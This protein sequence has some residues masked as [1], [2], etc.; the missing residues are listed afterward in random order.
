MAS[1]HEKDSQSQEIKSKRSRRLGRS[2]ARSATL[3]V[4]LA[5]LPGCAGSS[6]SSSRP[7]P[8]AAEQSWNRY[9]TESFDVY[10][11]LAQPQAREAMRSF[12]EIASAVDGL[13]AERIG[14]PLRQVPRVR[15]VVLQSRE[16]FDEISPGQASRTFAAYS[17]PR[18][19]LELEDIPT[20]VTF[21]EMSLEVR[22]R[23]V[24]QWVHHRLAHTFVDAPIWLNEGLAAYFERAVDLDGTFSMS[25]LPLT[26]PDSWEAFSRGASTLRD[27]SQLRTSQLLE[28]SRLVQVPAAKFCERGASRVHREDAETECA[29][30]YASAFAFVRLL[31]DGPAPYPNL[32]AT[33]VAKTRQGAS[34]QVAFEETFVSTSQKDVD[35]AFYHSLRASSQRVFM[36]SVPAR[37]GL[38]KAIAMPVARGEVHALMAN[39]EA[40]SSG[41]LNVARRWLA[42]APCAPGQCEAV[43]QAQ[44]VVALNDGAL[45][46]ARAHFDLALKAN[47]QSAHAALGLV[48]VARREA[49]EKG[50]GKQ[51]VEAATADLARLA[52]EPAQLN[53][54]AVV[55]AEA[56][57]LEDAQRF[58]ERAVAAGPQCSFCLDTLA[59]ILEARGDKDR[60]SWLS[61]EAARLRL[62]VLS[63]EDPRLFARSRR[64]A[65]W[66]F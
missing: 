39:I 37:T 62:Q 11:D 44:G 24:H 29:A 26:E 35:A 51:V 60:A 42:G 63:A 36:T 38:A 15:L 22:R 34:A 7:E 2:L 50:A 66:T 4:A 27:L 30:S 9:Q 6:N 41:D 58:A 61:Q 48:L 47:P 28:P 3:L 1:T 32:F 64:A 17:L 45:G 49:A 57:R 10:S 18:L 52:S 25:H 65:P 16:E 12:E 46:L 40:A 56:G 19:P 20:I 59:E 23:F 33:M 8:V 53:A 5:A 31:L 54:V 43:S 13:L 21:G 14:P 55:H